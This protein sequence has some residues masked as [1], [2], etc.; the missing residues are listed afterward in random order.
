MHAPTGYEYN[1]LGSGTWGT[2]PFLTF[3]YG[4]RVAPHANIGYQ[5]NGNSILAGDITSFTKAHLPNILNYSVGL[6]AGVAKRVSLS[7]DYLGQTLFHE[8]SILATTFTALTPCPSCGTPV[9]T[10]AANITS[11]RANIN[12]S[13]VSVGGKLNPF[14]RLLV[15]ANVLI[16]VNDAG[17]HYKPAPMVGLS[18]TF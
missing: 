15:T 9:D 6:D 12:Q 3:S 11:I 2:R 18:Y 17:L 16:R 8:Q 5:V 4:G 1:F 14:G 10:T 13:S 7:F